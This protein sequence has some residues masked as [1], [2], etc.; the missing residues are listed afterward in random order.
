MYHDSPIKF[1]KQDKLNRIQYSQALAKS[2][3]N[4]PKG[5]NSIVIGLM[6]E[7]GTGKSSLLNLIEVDIKKSVNVV[8]FNPWN[9]YSQ[10]TL[11]ASF[12]DELTNE[13]SFSNKIKTK[14][15][16]YKNKI[17]AAGISLGSSVVPQVGALTELISDSEHNTLNGIKNELD[18]IFKNQR[19]TVVIIDDLDRLNPDEVKQIFQLVKSLADFPNVIYILAFDKTYVNYALKEWNMDDETYS[20]TEDFINKIIQVPLIIPKFDEDSLFKIFEEK[21]EKIIFEHH[22]VDSDLDVTKLYNYLEPFF[23]NIRNINRY[24]ISL[25]FYLYSIDTEVWIFDF[26]LVTALQIFSKDVYGAVHYLILTLFL[27]LF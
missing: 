12:F 3:L 24:C 14:F 21:F 2:I 19:K 10:Q 8:R 22:V 18:N 9:Y 7:W 23:N 25:D 26:A 15:Q 16:K 13:L 17:Y 5:Q 4:I 1:K 6:G 20:H 11:F 27:G